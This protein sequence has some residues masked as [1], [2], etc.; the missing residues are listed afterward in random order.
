MSDTPTTEPTPVAEP[1]PQTEPQP[2]AEPTIDY[3]Q[4][5]NA[6]GTFKDDFLASLPDEIGKHSSISKY[7]NLPDLIKGTLNASSLVSKKAHEY[8]KSEDPEIVALR[9]EIMGVPKDASGYEFV[10][11]ADIPEGMPYDEKRVNDFA[12]FA[13]ENGVSKELAQKL[14]NYDAQQA[15]SAIKHVNAVTET[16]KAEKIDELRKEWGPKFDYNDAQ[17]TRAADYLGIRDILVET[18]L[19]YEPSVQKAILEKIIPAISS[20]KLIEGAK[21]DN[22]ATSI[23][24]LN[25]LESKIDSMEQSDPRYKGLIDQR[26]KILEKIN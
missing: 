20:D 2:V 11:P 21:E 15:M 6:D 19:A 14:I 3:S 24:S 7:S 12:Q 13:L 26:M 10:K 9:N 8:W 22:L 18:G 16:Y 25:E 5:I 17:V 1:T 4:K 23:E